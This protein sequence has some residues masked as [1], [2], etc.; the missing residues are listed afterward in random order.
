MTPTDRWTELRINGT[1]LA[2]AVV[3]AA[4]MAACCIL[5]SR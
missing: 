5:G 1:S 3:F 4:V 2:F